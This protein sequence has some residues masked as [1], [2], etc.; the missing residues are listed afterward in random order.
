MSGVPFSA[1]FDLAPG[2]APPSAPSAPTLTLASG[3]GEIILDW[4]DGSNGG[5]PIV[6]HPLYA[7][8]SLNT[9]ALVGTI[10]GPAPYRDQGLVNGVPRFYQLSARNQAGLESPRSAVATA[11]PV[12]L[13]AKLGTMRTNLDPVSAYSGYAVFLNRAKT[14]REWFINGGGTPT[15][16]SRGYPVNATG[17]FRGTIGLEYA[18]ELIARFGNAR[19]VLKWTGTGSVGLHAVAG[20]V[21]GTPGANRA[22]YT[23]TLNAGNGQTET[24]QTVLAISGSP[25]D[26]VVVP[27]ALEALYDGG[28]TLFDPLFLDY[29]KRY[30]VLRFMDWGVTNTKGSDAWPTRSTFAARSKYDYATWSNYRG[31]TNPERPE[32]PMEVMIALCNEAKCD[33][34]YNIPF[35]CVP[36]SGTTFTQAALHWNFIKDNLHSDLRAFIEFSNEVWNNGAFGQAQAALTKGGAHTFS[37]GQNSIG[38]GWYA[39]RCLPLMAAAKAD[40]AATPDRLVTCY[41]IQQGGFGNLGYIQQGLADSGHLIGD[42][43]D[44]VQ[45]TFYLDGGLNGLSGD[46]TQ[47]AIVAGW[48]ADIVAG[49]SA[50][51]AALTAMFNQIRNGNTAGFTDHGVNFVNWKVSEDTW[52]TWCRNNGVSKTFYEGQMYHIVH[53]GLADGT[54]LN[55]AL[56]GLSALLADAR[57]AVQWK[58]LAE[59]AN[60]VGSYG[61]TEFTTFGNVGKFGPW[62][63]ALSPLLPSTRSNMYRDWQLAPT[64]RGPLV[65][66]DPG[67]ISLFKDSPAN[68]PLGATGGYLPLRWRLASGQTLPAGVTIDKRKGILKGTPSALAAAGNV[69]V[70]VIDNAG[71]VASRTLSIAV[72]DAPTYEAFKTV[73]TGNNGSTIPIPFIQEVQCRVYNALGAR[74]A[75]AHTANVPDNPVYGDV[76]TL[77]DNDIGN[78]SKWSSNTDN[79]NAYPYYLVFT[80]SAPATFSKVGIICN[81]GYPD[82]CRGPFR[83][84]GKRVGTPTTA[85]PNS[86]VSSGNGWELLADYSAYPGGVNGWGI[87]ELQSERFFLKT[88]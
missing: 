16:D 30:D 77:D 37:N 87:D 53:L 61:F 19:V 27:E 11:T 15:L 52:A 59:Y 39:Y 36:D 74:V 10:T 38:D 71:T 83:I 35:E 79:P 8:A 64:L 2:Q 45:G 22:V 7:G 68:Q 9:I 81:G 34:H 23:A 80:P 63:S 55:N 65:F 54:P 1:N 49:G 40:F 21:V 86:D 67:A 26:I 48:N 69:I 6:S 88:V 46:A 70:D 42:V 78:S 28:T 60:S 20:T 73:I 33:M 82:R 56:A 4:T 25:K 24:Q 31:D 13:P 47:R 43:I 3:N 18:S 85:S 50:R 44:E 75:G 57:T 32:V 29:V 72:V 76:A 12:A 84:Y 5:S 62:G 41:G 17:D 14:L 58:D 51:A 66:N